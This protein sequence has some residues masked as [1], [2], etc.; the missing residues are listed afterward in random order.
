[1]WVVYEAREEEKPITKGFPLFGMMMVQ[2]SN[3]VIVK[4]GLKINVTGVRQ[5]LCKTLKWTK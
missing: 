1:M 4:S 3:N 5:K 2:G